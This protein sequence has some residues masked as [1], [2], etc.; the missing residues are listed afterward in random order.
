MTIIAELS[1]NLPPRLPQLQLPDLQE[2]P[3][4]KGNSNRNITY[5]CDN[6]GIKA[7]KSGLKVKRIQ[8]KEMGEGGPVLKTR[9]VAWL[10]L[11][12]M[13]SDPD[14]NRPPFTASPGLRDVQGEANA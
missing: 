5:Q 12:C 11:S 2:A 9:T 8:F 7:T 10:C 13:E 1:E 4:P 3:S 14:Y 6:C